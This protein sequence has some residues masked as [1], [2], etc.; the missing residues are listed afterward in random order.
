MQLATTSKFS[1]SDSTT[2]QENLSD[3]R[4][5]T[6]YDCQPASYDKWITDKSITT[7]SEILVYWPVNKVMFKLYANDTFMF[8][9][10]K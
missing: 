8:V 5:T 4:I 3:F 9:V 6:H 7:V 2:N 10:K 1:E